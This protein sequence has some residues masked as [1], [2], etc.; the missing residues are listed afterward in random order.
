MKPWMN[1]PGFSHKYL[2]MTQALVDQ[3]REFIAWCRPKLNLPEGI[4][5]KLINQHIQHGDQKTFGYWDGDQNMIVICVKDR[6][7]T[8]VLR[9]LAHELVHVAQNLMHPLNSSDGVTGS[10]VENEANALA[11][12]LMRLWNSRS[13][14]Y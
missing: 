11:G 5:V 12:I 9:T 13:I 3:V 2:I 7:P 10:D 14:N 8:D 4:R 1:H 6:H